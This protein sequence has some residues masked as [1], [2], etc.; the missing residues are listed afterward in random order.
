MSKKLGSITGINGNMISVAFKDSVIQNEVGFVILDKERLMSE[1]IRIRGNIAYMQV[2]ENTKGIKV[3]ESPLT[4]DR[5]KS[6]EVGKGHFAPACRNDDTG[7]RFFDASARSGRSGRK[8]FETIR[9][10]P[11]R[12]CMKPSAATCGG[13]CMLICACP[14][15]CVACAPSLKEGRERSLCSF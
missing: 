9:E 2:F 4:T 3:G 11:K 8:P 10:D 13:L 15:G 5:V 6:E 1:V 14:H 12:R 7:A